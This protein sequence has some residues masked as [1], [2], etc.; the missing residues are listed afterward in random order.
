MW[1]TLI[2]SPH[3]FPI[4]QVQDDFQQWIVDTDM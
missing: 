3:Y 4:S 1:R 2:M